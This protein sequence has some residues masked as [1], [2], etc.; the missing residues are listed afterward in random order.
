MPWPT[1][2]QVYPGKM[3][4]YHFNAFLQGLTWETLRKNATYRKNKIFLKG[5]YIQKKMFSESNDIIL[6]PYRCQT[7][8]PLVQWRY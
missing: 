5:Y 7:E 2:Q 8:E 4:I 3:L 6:P 1:F